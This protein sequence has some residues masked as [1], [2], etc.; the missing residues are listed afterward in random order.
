M[1]KTIYLENGFN[2]NT[3]NLLFNG[4]YNPPNEESNSYDNYVTWQTIDYFTRIEEFTF[5][6]NLFNLTKYKVLKLNRIKYNKKKKQYE[7]K[8]NGTIIGFNKLSD[9]TEN[10][11]YD[12]EL[13]SSNRHHKCINGCLNL[14]ASVPNSRIVTG[15]ITMNNEKHLHH[16]VEYDDKDKTYVFDYTRNLYIEKEQ[17]IKITKFVEV[18]SSDR[19]NTLDN[20]QILELINPYFSLKTYFTF[21]DEILTDIKKNDFL[22][23]DEK[24]KKLI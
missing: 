16:I 2:E 8:F 5:F 1:E 3:Y 21:T 22:F 7:Y 10:D 4:I 24:I 20:M 15:Y 6:E 14:N 23:E 19:K 12:R 9:Y 13:L 18:N 17:Y 11:K